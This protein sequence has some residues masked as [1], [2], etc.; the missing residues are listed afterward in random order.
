VGED[1]EF[2]LTGVRGTIILSAFAMG[3]AVLESITQAGADLL[4]TPLELLGTEQLGDVVVTLTTDTGRLEGVVT[5][6]GTEPAIDASVMVFPDDPDKWFQGSPFVFSTRTM[7]E[8][9]AGM[10][11]PRPGMPLRTPGSFAS[12][13]LL[14]GRY[15]V[16]ATEVDGPAMPT[17][18]RETLEKLR[19]GAT[20][21]TVTVGATARV[22]VTLRRPN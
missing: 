2:Q 6:N 5:K 7:G 21:V 15:Y 13:N 1:G 3:T 8:M 18:D 14:P 22:Q 19:T 20:S 9:P 11:P 4:A 10:P 16:V 17:L 12:R